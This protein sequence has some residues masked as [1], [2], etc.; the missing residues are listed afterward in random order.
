ME[1]IEGFP[2]SLF[3]FDVSLTPGHSGGIIG[4]IVHLC[5]RCPSAKII[6]LVSRLPFYVASQRGHLLW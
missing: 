2:V 5:G 1:N 6:R 3:T 4:E